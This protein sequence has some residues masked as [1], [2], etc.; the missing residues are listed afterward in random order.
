MSQTPSRRSKS[1]GPR[2]WMTSVKRSRRHKWQDKVESS[3]SFIINTFSFQRIHT[4][5]LIVRSMWD[6]KP[7]VTWVISSENG[8]LIVLK[9]RNITTSLN[10]WPRCWRKVCSAVHQ[11]WFSKSLFLC[12]SP[13]FS[14]APKGARSRSGLMKVGPKKRRR[15]MKS[16]LRSFVRWP[17]T[18]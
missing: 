13:N 10:S 14:G 4:K 7:N 5:F 2:N 11:R 3:K 16:F 18:W 8:R 1:V 15:S 9:Q 17:A 6:T 12:A